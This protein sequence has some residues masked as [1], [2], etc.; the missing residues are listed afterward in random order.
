MYVCMYVYMRLRS[1][2]VWSCLL[3]TCVTVNTCRYGVTVS[4]CC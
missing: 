4:L 3:G 1:V 2:L